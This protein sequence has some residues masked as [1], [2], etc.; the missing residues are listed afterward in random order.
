MLVAIQSVPN[1]LENGISMAGVTSEGLKSLS[2]LL[3]C[4]YGIEVHEL[5]QVKE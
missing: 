5:I 3:C 4:I 1:L 2:F